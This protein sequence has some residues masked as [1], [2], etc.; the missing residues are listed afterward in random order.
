MDGGETLR[1]GVNQKSTPPL[2]FHPHRCCGGSGAPK[3]KI[4][5]NFGTALT[6]GNLYEIFKVCGQLYPGLGI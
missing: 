6:L 1:A 4:L 2:K 5:C 3:L